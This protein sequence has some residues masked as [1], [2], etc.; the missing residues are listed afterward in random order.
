MSAVE[1][2][3]GDGGRCAHGWHIRR[4]LRLLGLLVVSTALLRV[5]RLAVRLRGV[6]SAVT[7]R[8]GLTV[9]G[10]LVPSV[11]LLLVVAWRFRDVATISKEQRLRERRRTAPP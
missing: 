4:L 6:P 3:G 10:L 8:R 1:R 9:R 5:S 11:A 2:D 7:A